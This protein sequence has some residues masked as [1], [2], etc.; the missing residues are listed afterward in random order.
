MN[1][2]IT[3]DSAAAGA[4]YLNGGSHHGGDGSVVGPGMQ[5][6][7]PPISPQQHQS[8]AADIS[9][10]GVPQSRGPVALGAHITP[11]GA[12]HGHV[13]GTGPP[14]GHPAQ[15]QAIR[16]PQGPSVKTDIPMSDSATVSPLSTESQGDGAGSPSGAAKR[17]TSGNQPIAA[18]NATEDSGEE[19]AIATSSSSESSSTGMFVH[20]NW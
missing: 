17:P 11:P 4:T 5:V 3:G 19:K 18:A 2:I 14:P 15:G 9:P 10:S 20:I 8:V 6:T 12:A 13:A 16:S 7:S 1:F